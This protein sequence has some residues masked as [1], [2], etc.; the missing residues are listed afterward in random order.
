MNDVSRQRLRASLRATTIAGSLVLGGCQSLLPVSFS[1]SSLG[2]ALD[3][4]CDQDD[5]PS[6]L[7]GKTESPPAN[8]QK[9]EPAVI[10]A[11]DAK[12]G[13]FISPSLAAKLEGA[14]KGETIPRTPAGGPLTLADVVRSAIRSSAQIGLAAA[15]R[16]ETEAAVD[17]ARAAYRPFLDIGS[18]SGQNTYGTLAKTAT[19]DYFSRNNL[20]GSWRS[21]VKLTGSMMVYDFGAVD[22][23][24]T[25][26]M[27][28]R[29]AAALRERAA[30]EDAA[31]TAAQLYVRVLQSRELLKLA[32]ENLAALKVIAG[33]IATNVQNGNA[34]QADTQRVEARVLDA[35][36]ARADQQ[37]ELRSSTE[38]FIR[39]VNLQ[40]GELRTPPALDSAM[41]PT[42]DR[43]LDEAIRK[44]PM[45][46]ANAAVVAAARAEAAA[47]KST[48][49]PRVSFDT[50][51]TSKTYRGSGN[52]TELDLT[53]MLSLSYR[54]A[55]GGLGSAKVDQASARLTQAQIRDLD[56]RETLE[57]DIRQQYL[58]YTSAK[59]KRDGL[60]AGVKTSANARELYQEQFIGGKRTLLEL[61]EV[62]N[63][64]YTARFNSIV[65][66]SD[67]RLSTFS[68]LRSTGRLASTIL[69]QT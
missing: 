34:T 22:A 11:L 54:L 24:V 61:L 9:A 43:G 68:I 17:A 7:I 25:R 27:S 51:A 1:C 52:K 32:D 4:E 53:A 39:I 2:A 55:D 5:A 15:S 14:P 47:L 20:N 13:S 58:Q 46:I 48:Q 41:P 23:D 59:A 28:A 56:T 44:N 29:D 45:V 36:S 64:Y 65:N 33:L 10:A 35:E 21:D 26:A 8:P 6:T 63:A 3:A 67:L 57:A 19:N 12:P 66:A 50:S 38:R 62:Q 30:S 49:M 40:P 18:G 60:L 37:L 31:F 16:S 42:V 69:G